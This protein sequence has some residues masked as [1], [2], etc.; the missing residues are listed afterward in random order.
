MQSEDRTPW[1][2]FA[3]CGQLV[4]V[5]MLLEPKGGDPFEVVRV[6]RQ[7]VEI[8]AGLEK[9][10]PLPPELVRTGDML[11]ATLGLAR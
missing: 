11:K 5:D 1:N 9:R 7:G 10:G 2:P 6:A 8:L 3:A 4:T